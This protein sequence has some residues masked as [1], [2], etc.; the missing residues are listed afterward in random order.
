[1]ARRDAPRFS[2]LSVIIVS[3]VIAGL[4]VSGVVVMLRLEQKRA[5]KRTEEQA[6]EHARHWATIVAGSL[7]TGASPMGDNLRLD[8]WEVK[9]RVVE[10]DRSAEGISGIVEA[11]EERTTTFGKSTIHRCFSYDIPV[12][13]RPT[14]RFVVEPSKCPPQLP[15]IGG[16]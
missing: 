7:D 3:V 1:M 4:V 15:V 16:G 5:L 9:V 10:I 12:R 8:F 2:C 11:E 13:T 14:G 6:L